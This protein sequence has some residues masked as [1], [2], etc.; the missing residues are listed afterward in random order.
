MKVPPVNIFAFTALGMNP[1]Y[2]S[3]N[4][5][6]D[7]AISITVRST[8]GA[9]AEIEISHDQMVELREALANCNLEDVRRLAAAGKPLI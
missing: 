4:E 1:P 2:I 9:Q 7:G 5:A 3:V 8:T 6:E